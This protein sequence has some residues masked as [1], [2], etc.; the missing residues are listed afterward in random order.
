MG[1][2]AREPPL[3]APAA[4]IPASIAR[5]MDD[6]NR[7]VLPEKRMHVSLMSFGMISP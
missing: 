7:S 3:Q 4:A 1:V 6:L 2:A 5:A